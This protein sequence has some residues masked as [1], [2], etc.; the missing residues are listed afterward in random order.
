MLLQINSVENLSKD[1][2]SLFD[3]YGQMAIDGIVSYAPKILIAIL[4]YIVGNWIIG[5]IVK[6]V[7]KLFKTKKIDESL[8]GFLVSTVKV[9]LII[10]LF[11][12]IA[13]QIGINVT[14]FAALLAGAGLAIGGA[15]NGSLG[16]LAGGVMILLFKPFKVGEQIEAQGFVGIVKEIGIF[17]TKIITADNKTVILPNGALSTGVI[18]NNNEEGSLRVDLTID[19][20]NTKDFPKAQKIALEVLS[21][22]VNVLK[23]PVPTVAILNVGGGKTTLAIRPFCE[24]QK[25]WDVYFNTVEKINFAFIENG[26]NAPIPTNI[27]LTKEME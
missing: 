21:S 17:A 6:V 1:T 15:M 12:A 27:M 19:I 7:S 16:N 4:M 18:T 22:D 2:V 8:A 14:G 26:I 20:A 24:Q 5:K 3:K 25:Y 13:S 23:N 9:L 11:L 10:L